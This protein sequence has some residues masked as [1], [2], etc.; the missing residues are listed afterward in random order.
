MRENQSTSQDRNPK[1][2][3][4]GVVKSEKEDAE[5]MAKAY[6]D[7]MPRRFDPFFDPWPLPSPGDFK[8]G[9]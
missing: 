8:R 6:L 5:K 9:A 7:V 1:S 2:R 3:D 4:A